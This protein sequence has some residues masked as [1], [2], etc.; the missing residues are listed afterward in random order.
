M[1]S[2]PPGARSAMRW[3][4][5]AHRWLGGT[6]GL[7]LALIG[8][9]GAVLVHREAWTIVPH[10]GD[11]P[12][13]Q[14]A[15]IASTVT[16]IMTDPVA[17]ARTITF[18]SPGFGVDR[19]AYG[20]GGAY[21][22]QTGNVLV[23]WDNQWSRP[24]LWLA[25]FH[26]HLFTG[27]TGKTVIGVA[28]LAGLFFIATGMMLWWRTRRTFAFRLLP[29][30]LGRPAIVRHHRDLG[31]VAAPLLLLSCAT[32]AVLV[33]RPL[34][35]VLLGP[36]AAAAIEA[37]VKPPRTPAVPLR[38]DL[39]WGR[40][41]HTARGRFPHADFRTVSL[42][43]GDSG[44][45]TIRMKQPWEWLPNGRTTLWFA[46]DTGDLV[47]AH[48]PARSARQ[49]SAYNLLYPL[50]AGKVGGLPYRLLM[51]A[52]GM[53]LGFLG[54]LAVWTFWFG[55]RRRPSRAPGAQSPSAPLAR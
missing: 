37:T 22:D 8:F 51:T 36:G 1:A 11:A 18:A 46:A 38:R 20:E 53:A 39:D 41:V 2:S 19:V 25:D 16:R 42:P 33:F 50:H 32:G 27:D 24:E 54:T 45:V 10:K 40:M 48:D 31:V 13:Q 5:L 4:E 15:L 14:S 55:R 9:S 43:R 6:I 29:K 35:S 49:V 26:Q 34:S 7:L 30:R 44:L 3:I 28:G 17:Q 23:R 12:V 52:S 47:S 21:T